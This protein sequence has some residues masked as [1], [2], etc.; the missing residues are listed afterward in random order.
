MYL[1]LDLASRRGNGIRWKKGQ[2]KINEKTSLKWKAGKE[3]SKV[4]SRI[5]LSEW[6]LFFCVGE[7]NKG[8]VWIIERQN[9]FEV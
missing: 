2:N 3:L 7:I 6:R 4:T 9:K 5:I 1:F 8:L